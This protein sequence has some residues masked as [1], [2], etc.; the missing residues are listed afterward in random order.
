MKPSIW[1]PTPRRAH[2]CI[3][4]DPMSF[5]VF[6][7]FYRA[8]GCEME[9]IAGGLWGL[10]ATQ[11]LPVW[12]AGVWG[13]ARLAVGA[14]PPPKSRQRGIEIG[15]EYSN[16]KPTHLLPQFRLVRRPIQCIMEY[17]VTIDEY[18]ATLRRTPE[19]LTIYKEHTTAVVKT[20]IKSSSIQFSKF[21][22]KAFLQLGISC[23]NSIAAFSF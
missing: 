2:P 9:K 11:R 16:G 23:S 14:P 12:D 8:S 18:W 3:R 1:F 19:R 22:L 17:T 10:L 4:F 21:S 15:A 20:E 13:L 6:N 7:S 5:G